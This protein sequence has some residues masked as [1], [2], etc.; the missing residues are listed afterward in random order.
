ML[1][2]E[3]LRELSE[4]RSDENYYVSLY[5]NVNPI[6]NPKGEY[7]VHLK[8]MIR[9]ISENTGK[10]V[11]K[12]IR[13]DLE[14]LT[15]YV[16]SNKREFRKGLAILSSEGE[17][18]WREYNLSV[19]VKNSLTVDHAPYIKPLLDILDNNPRY[20]VLIV[21]KEEARIFVVHLGEIVEYGEVKTMDVPGRHKKG[22]WFALAEP[23]YQRHIDYH[24]G[25]HLKEVIKR[26][27]SFI[28]AERID[29]VFVG[30]PDEAVTMFE[31]M[32][33]ETV[34]A[35]IKG[36]FSAEMFL[37]PDEVLKRVEP[38]LAVYES[39]KEKKI[40]EELITRAMKGD[41]AVLGLADVIGAVSEGKVHRLIFVK[42]YSESGFKCVECSLVSLEA[43]PRCP[44]CGSETEPIE[45]LVELVAQR[46]VEHGATVEVLAYETDSLKE[47]GGIG[48]IL[49]F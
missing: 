41:Q 40:V 38:L 18:F 7:V 9:E 26:L 43:I 17:G 24:V 13:S 45:Y 4:I 8:N 6:T 12:K 23:H 36:R 29:V 31:E 44:Y 42:D 14:K 11:Y 30:G 49:R 21:E 5:L 32:L 34:R 33:P 47:R 22:G 1:N 19:P 37:K 20:L 27:E 25:L 10:D 35:K 3:E 2:R 16:T 46:A 28:S 39:E 15:A 48:A